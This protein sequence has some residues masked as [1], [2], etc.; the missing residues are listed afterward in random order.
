MSIILVK[1]PLMDGGVMINFVSHY[2]YYNVIFIIITTYGYVCRTQ[3]L[4]D[5]GVYLFNVQRY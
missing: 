2:Y 5:R 4:T 3:R 1:V